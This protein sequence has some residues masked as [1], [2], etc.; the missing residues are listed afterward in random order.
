MLSVH[1]EVSSMP[2]G[3]RNCNYLNFNAFYR[4]YIY[5]CVSGRNTL[6]MC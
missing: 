1:D 6:K 5:E 4:Q 2:E 3:T